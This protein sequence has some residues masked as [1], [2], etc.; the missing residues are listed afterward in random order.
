[1]GVSSGEGVFA[2]KKQGGR[3]RTAF[4]FLMYCVQYIYSCTYI[5]TFEVLYM[6]YIYLGIQ[7]SISTSPVLWTL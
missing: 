7:V 1:M 6:V 5:P 3:G 4:N 2:A